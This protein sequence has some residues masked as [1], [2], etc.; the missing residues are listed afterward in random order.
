M[1]TPPTDRR[2][3]FDD[4]ADF[5]V[6]GE[7]G[8]V[9]P[10]ISDGSTFTFLDP[11][12]ME[13]MF[14]GGSEGCYL[15][16]RQE[17]PSGHVLGEALAR[18][19]GTEGAHATA[20]GMAAIAATLF[21]LCRSGSEILAE[22]TVYGGTYALL[23]NFFPRYGITTRF[24][25]LTDLEA[26]RAA[27]HPGVS[28]VYAESLTNPLLRTPPIRALADL[29]H[30]HG[31]PL[32]V[33]NTFAP[34]VMTPARE[35]A[36][37]VVHSL[38]KFINGMSDCVGGAICA[39]REFLARLGDVHDGALMLLGPSMDSLRAAQIY[40]NLHTLPL[41]M[42]VHGANALTYASRLEALG[43]RVTYPGL[44]GYVDREIFERQ[45]HERY[46]YGGLLTLDAGD[47]PTARQL[48]L[49]LQDARVGWLAVSLGFY[50]TLFSPSGVSTSSE[51]PPEEREVMGLGPGL[52]RI[53]VGLDHDIERSWQRFAR[54]L[55][56]LPLPRSDV[57]RETKAPA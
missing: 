31:V 49:R 47:L 29:A 10:S 27:F 36:D 30:E 46:G 13:E 8:E 15:Y 52:V 41:R 25:D 48:V 20:S 16:S 21:A 14:Q 6:F 32:V 50:R 7:F 57:R 42:R 45:R 12:R 44:A 1:S 17:N 24:L 26:V 19:E 38:T 18:L 56:G 28:V 2:D 51:I 54:C 3:P 23:R 5:Q 33:D 9:N 22:R 40:K 53:S 35:G 11:L 43:Y 39:S 4:V 55:E 34:L 37:V